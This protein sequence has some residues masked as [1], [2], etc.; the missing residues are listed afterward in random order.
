MTSE[1]K[2]HYCDSTARRIDGYCSYHGYMLGTRESC[3]DA[4]DPT[5]LAARM[6]WQPPMVWDDIDDPDEQHPDQ[7]L[8]ITL[9]EGERRHA[10]TILD[11]YPP[12]VWPFDIGRD[13]I[14]AIVKGKRLAARPAT[15]DLLY[16]ETERIRTVKRHQGGER[17]AAA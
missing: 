6:Q 13:S 8:H 10:R 9:T 15:I 7:F 17:R 1:C 11:M 16:A 2:Y 5:K 3:T 14:V 12:R 4:G